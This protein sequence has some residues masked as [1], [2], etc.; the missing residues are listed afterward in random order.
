ML[1]EATAGAKDKRPLLAVPVIDFSP[2][3]AGDDAGKRQVAS[4]IDRAC[5]EVGFFVLT[6]H[7]V[8]QQLLDDWLAVSRDFFHLPAE[9]KLRAAPAPGDFHH[10]YHRMAAEGLAY[11]DA[12]G[13]GKLPPPDLREFFAVGRDGLDDAYYRSA[14][15]ARFYKAN[16]WPAHP[17]AFRD[18]A[19]AY[20]SAADGL[21]NMLLRAAALAFGLPEAYFDDKVDRSFST[22]STIHYPAQREAPLPG[23]L[24]AGVHTDY[25]SLTLVAQTDPSGGLQALNRRG[26][27]IDVP[28]VKGA[29]A[30]N[31]GDMMAQWTND[32]WVSTPHRV[33]NPA[34][35]GAHLK[36][37]QSVAYFQH[38]NYDTVIA[39]L[40]SC[41]DASRPPRH[42][43]VTSGDYI[44]G[45]VNRIA[46]GLR[47]AAATP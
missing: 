18:I 9:E 31:V 17:P 39:C 12:A 5:R 6:G 40:P 45:K 1:D 20:F 2:W 43:D 11:K 23:Q 4:A 29:F 10:G 22:L 38:P 35:D 25:T 24:R 34:Q 36:P 19:C 14:D 26:E 7:T 28:Y 47:E 27:W 21:C 30:V 46:P 32:V 41:T 33:V 42:A 3:L 13:D 15:A 37:R 44:W 16:I 8:S